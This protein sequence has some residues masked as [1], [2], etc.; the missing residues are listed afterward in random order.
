LQCLPDLFSIGYVGAT[1]TLIAQT[2]AIKAVGGFI[3]DRIVG[4]DAELMIR[5]GTLPRA[6][7]IQSPSTYGYRLHPGK[8]SRKAANWSAGALALIKRYDAGAFPGGKE[9][10]HQV[11]KIVSFNAAFCALTCALRGDLL[12][13]VRLYLKTFFWQLHAGEYSHLVK[14]PIRLLLCSVGLWP[15]NAKDR[16]AFELM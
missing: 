12:E 5:L 3:K 11:R 8:I 1:G 6:I 15:L 13:G 7:R 2:Q 16:R 4:E 14:T 10:S 9:R